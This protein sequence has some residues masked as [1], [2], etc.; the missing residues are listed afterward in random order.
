MKLVAWAA[1]DTGRKRDHN[2]DNFLLSDD[3]GLFAVADGMGGHQGGET[4]SRIAVETLREKVQPAISDLTAAAARIL[5]RQY[6][7]GSRET[8]PIRVLEAPEL[9]FG[10]GPTDPAIALPDPPGAAVMA[11]AARSAGFA[12]FDAALDD[13]ALRGM[14]TTLTAMLH[15]DGVMHIV[16]AGDSRAYLFRDRKLDQVTEDHSWI[17]EQVKAGSMTEREARESQFRHIITRSV[18]FERDVVVDKHNIEIEPGDCFLLCS[19]GMSNYIDGDELER[20]LDTNFYRRC[21]RL[22]IDLANDRG[23]DDNITVVVIYVANDAS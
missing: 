4:A 5:R 6:G 9:E 7:A 11:E 19:D 20:V 17:A 23:G 12:I 2:E 15:H 18:G 8:Q 10:E 3:L 21:P 13:P 22:L 16:H 1:T 14:G